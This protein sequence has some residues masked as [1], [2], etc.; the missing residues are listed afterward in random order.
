M[1]E[2]DNDAK[3]PVEPADSAADQPAADQAAT[4]Q[5]PAAPPTAPPAAP[6]FAAPTAPVATTRWRDRVFRFRSVA[7]V[8]VAGVII[9]AAGGAVTTAVVSGDRHGDHDRERMGQVWQPGMMPAVPPGQRQRFPGG[10]SQDWN[11]PPMPVP[12]G[13]GDGTEDGTDD[14]SDNGTDDQSS[15]SPS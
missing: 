12:P 15:P 13:N 11:L 1:S 8:A 3:E 4:D 7:A 14:G 6:A 2:H 5:P 9:G 10:D